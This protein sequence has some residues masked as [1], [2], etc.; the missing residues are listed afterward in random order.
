MVM[1]EYMYHRPV[2]RCERIILLAVMQTRL[3]FT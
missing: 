3:G 1:E 2:H